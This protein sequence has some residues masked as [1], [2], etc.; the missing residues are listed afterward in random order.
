MSKLQDLTGQKFG[1]LLVV[2]RCE[3]YVTPKGQRKVQYLCLCD[4]QLNLP[5]EERVY[6]KVLATNLKRNH[7]LSCG[8]INVERMKVLKKKYNQYDLESYDYGVGYDTNGAYFYFDKQYYNILKD[9]YWSLT[10]D[11]Y[12]DTRINKKH[13][14]MHRLLMDVLDNHSVDI[15]HINHKT[16]DNRMDNLR[17]AT[18]SQNM[19]NQSLSKANT[20]GETGVC[21][22]KDRYVWYSRITVDGA[23]YFLGRFNNYDDAIDARK[24]AEEKYF[25]EWSYDNSMKLETN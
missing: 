24:Q 16:Y 22:D 5:E 4:C 25:G 17:Q 14:K 3:D 1:R 18:R 12:W 11:G 6:I 23:T 2:C 9:H 10:P 19:M 15:D 8:C 20:S 13:I 7:S 21:W